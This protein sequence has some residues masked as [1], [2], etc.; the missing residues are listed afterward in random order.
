MPFNPAISSPL[1][2]FDLLML[3]RV[4]CP[5]ESHAAWHWKF[6]C[7]LSLICLTCIFWENG[8]AS[9]YIGLWPAA[10]A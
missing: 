3:L 10:V 8:K 4:L 2:F 6:L 1:L 5:V 7:N 9:S